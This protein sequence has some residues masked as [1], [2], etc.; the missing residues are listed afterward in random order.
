MADDV[1]KNYSL[2]LD[3]NSLRNVFAHRERG[4]YIAKINNFALR[5]LEC[6]GYN[7]KAGKYIHSCTGLG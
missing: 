5:K 4:K 7:V 6:N 1:S 3:L 2:A